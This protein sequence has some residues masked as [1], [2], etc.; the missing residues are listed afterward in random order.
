MREKVPPEKVVELAVK[1]A[2]QSP[3]AK[4]KRGAVIYGAG[5]HM[6]AAWNRLPREFTCDASEACKTACARRCIHAEEGALMLAIG[7]AAPKPLRAL[8]V[9]IV[10]TGRA[11]DLHLGTSTLVGPRGSIT[12]L[13]FAA[14]AFKP[15]ASG[16]PSCAECA[17]LMLA[18]GLEGVWLLD[19]SGWRFW[20]MLDFYTETMRTLGLKDD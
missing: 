13:P 17:K 1:A 3:C 2:S 8:H 20:S 5:K 11:M 10:P 18:T 9:K 6:F 14:D 12:H 16:P 4:S 15:V 7:G 19:D